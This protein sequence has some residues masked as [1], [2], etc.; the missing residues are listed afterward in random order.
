MK[1]SGLKWLTQPRVSICATG[2][3]INGPSPKHFSSNFMAAQKPPPQ[4]IITSF[5]W[6]CFGTAFVWFSPPHP[7]AIQVCSVFFSLSA[8]S[9]H[10]AFANAVFWCFFIGLFNTC[11]TAAC[12]FLFLR[13]ASL[14]GISGGLV[15]GIELGVSKLMG[16]PRN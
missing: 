1:R 14:Y 8:R 12:P 3:N 16:K 5:F 15:A 10:T 13:G 7:R 6:T 2:V 11:P 9:L 4:S